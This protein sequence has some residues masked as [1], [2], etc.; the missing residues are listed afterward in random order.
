MSSPPPVLPPM[1]SSVLSENTGSPNSNMKQ[2]A[3]SAIEVA[4]FQDDLTR[5]AAMQSFERDLSDLLLS[6][7][8]ALLYALSVAKAQVGLNQTFTGIR[9]KGGEIGMQLIRAVTV[10][11]A[12]ISGASVPVTQ[13]D[14]TYASGGWNNVF[15][16]AAVPVNLAQTGVS[17]GGA[18][19]QFSRCMLAFGSFINDQ[20]LP[21]LREYRW[22][23]GQKDFPIQSVAWQ[24]GTN[25]IYSKLAGVVI[26]PPNGKF[27]MRGNLGASGTDGTQL[28]G[29][30]FATG[31][32][33]NSET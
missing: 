3:L 20:A 23:M 12:G 18:T 19:N 11:N 13:W 7:Y 6:D 8:D 14:Q 15:G 27:Y 4:T 1:P 22:H 30:C 26:I 21:L 17:A 32:Y 29:L 5:L 33:L 24:P 16:S 10:L 9:A 28:F 25:F 31:D 2:V